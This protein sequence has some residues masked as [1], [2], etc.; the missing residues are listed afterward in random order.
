MVYTIFLDLDGV[1]AQFIEE[2]LKRHNKSDALE[3]W[4]VGEWDISK[5]L[6]ITQ[7]E[8]WKKIKGFE[9]WKNLKEYPYFRRLLGDLKNLGEVIF[10]TSCSQDSDCAKGKIEWMQDR[11]GKEFK[12]YIL[13][14]HKYF[15]ANK[16]SILIDDSDDNIT[17]FKN[18]GGH[19]ILVPQKWNSAKE[20]PS[21]EDQMRKIIISKVIQIQKKSCDEINELAK[22]WDTKN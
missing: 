20:A 8:F 22:L 18:H 11:F 16:N 15:C 10:L 13:T 17:E 2:A 19:G 5:V 12:D 21:D 1:C 14:K 9:F 4:P 3:T 7:E 6:G